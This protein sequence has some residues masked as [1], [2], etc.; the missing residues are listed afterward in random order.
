M[1][2]DLEPLIVS[3]PRP[4]LDDPFTK[5]QIDAVVKDMP[6]D[7]AHGP[8]GFNGLFIKHCCGIII[9][10]VYGLCQG[11]YNGMI[12]LES[13]NS[14]FITLIPRND[15]PLSVNDYKSISLL[16]Y[17]LKLITKILANRLQQVILQ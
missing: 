7:H 8:D 9:E 15:T 13:I 16:N 11:F 2:Y 6:P 4:V 14:L 5:K 12:D 3:L 10:D 1:V 17:S